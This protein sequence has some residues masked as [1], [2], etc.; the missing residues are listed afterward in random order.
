M[1]EPF[2]IDPVSSK[3]F[4]AQCQPTGM[5]CPR[6]TC[7]L[8]S[9]TAWHLRLLLY[10]SRL[11][12]CINLHLH[13]VF[14]GSN[15]R[16]YEGSN[17]N[18]TCKCWKCLSCIILAICSYALLAYIKHYE[19]RVHFQKADPINCKAGV[20]PAA[21]GSINT[22]SG[23]GTGQKHFLSWLGGSPEVCMAGLDCKMTL[24]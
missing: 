15:G 17:R 24:R 2:G 13:L 9:Q 11:N 7:E 23:S 4:T 12:V 6:L 19:A 3:P 20:H 22:H 14:V 5:N 16:F 18:T 21:A 8:V 10:I 1:E